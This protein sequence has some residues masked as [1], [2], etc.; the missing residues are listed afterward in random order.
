VLSYDGTRFE[1]GTL[2]SGIVLDAA[3]DYGTREFT[4]EDAP[5]PRADGRTFGQDYLAGTT[6]TFTLAVHGTD[7]QECRQKLAALSRAWRGDSIRKTPNAVATL[8][9]DT[10]QVCY[11]RPRRFAFDGAELPLGVAIVTCDFDTTDNLWYSGLEKSAS[12]TFYPNLGGGLVAPLTAP[13]S[14]TLTSDRSRSFTVGGD[15]DTWPTFEVRGPITNPVLEIVDTLRIELQT[16]LGDGQG[17][18]IN[19]NPHARSILRSDGVSLAGTVTR[20]ST[21]LSDCALPPGTY[22]LVL[23]GKSGMRDAVAAIRWREATSV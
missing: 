7:E 11:G 13:L 1:F 12:I 14:T 22:E 19:T 4:T 10:G 6:I 23:R 17:L 3:P 16:T 9:S 18:I 20:K 21:R 2:A 15:T 8:Q 5:V